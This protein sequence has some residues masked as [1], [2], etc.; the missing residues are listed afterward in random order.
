[1]FSPKG[2]DLE[3]GWPGRIEGDRVVQ[4]AAQTLQA[5]F[6]GGGNAR[7]HAEFQLEEVD[8][9]PPVL[10]PPNVRIFAGFE[11][12]PEPFFSFRSTAEILGPEAD[13]P[14]PLG[15]RELDFGLGLGA[16]IGAD[17]TVG[18]FTIANDWTARDLEGT[19]RAAGFGPSKSKDFALSIGPWLV[20][21]DELDGNGGTLIG[22][23]GGEERS[24][25]DLGDL[26]Y[27]WDVLVAHAA[28][29]TAL[30]AG[31][32]LVCSASGRGGPWLSAGDV[33]EL[34]LEGFG[35]LRNRVAAS[36]R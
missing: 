26:A 16:V 11:R 17:G 10:H 27:G 22:R 30:R 13:V 33:V 35:V 3:R 14:Y 23:V 8:L 7:E 34:E 1:M 6:T 9:R 4:L 29:N 36:R 28:R 2:A 31:D 15:T 21:P 24:R 5:F 18:G 19:E 25:V 32:L 12:L 20:T